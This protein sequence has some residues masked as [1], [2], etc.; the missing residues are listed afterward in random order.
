MPAVLR[1]EGQ[2]VSVPRDRHIVRKPAP[3]WTDHRIGAWLKEPEIEV[4]LVLKSIK[5]FASNEVQF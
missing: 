5:L 2:V 1:S 4:G 3:I